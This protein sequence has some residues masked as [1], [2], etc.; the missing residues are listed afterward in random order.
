LDDP[1]LDALVNGCPDHW[2]AL[3]A[4]HACQAGKDVYVEKPEGHNISESRVMVAAA[5]KYQRGVRLGTQARSGLMQA[6][7]IA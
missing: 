2:H 4:I 1:E 5:R 7:A 3:P 6:E